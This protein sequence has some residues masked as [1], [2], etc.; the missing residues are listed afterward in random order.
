M[1]TSHLRSGWSLQT[2]MKLEQLP[3]KTWHDQ[4]VR[5]TANSVQ[6]VRQLCKES[7][8]CMWLDIPEALGT[9][10]RATFH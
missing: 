2:I 9:G 6:F 3:G 8:V 5:P 10:R 1:S 4:F 7:K